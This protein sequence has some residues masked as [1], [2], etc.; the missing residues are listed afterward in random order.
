MV[1]AASGDAGHMDRLQ[2]RQNA[3]HNDTEAGSWTAEGKNASDLYSCRGDAGGIRS[4]SRRR[5][6]QQQSPNELE[7][8]WHVN[9]L[10]LGLCR[11][12]LCTEPT[13]PF[14]KDKKKV[15]RRRKPN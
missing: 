13:R 7:S 9:R 14:F 2:E 5:K 8:I 4:I 11:A 12:R 1:R 6:S 3:N 15:K 10:R